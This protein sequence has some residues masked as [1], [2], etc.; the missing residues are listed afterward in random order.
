MAE[1]GNLLTIDDKPVFRADQIPEVPKAPYLL[2]KGG[3]LTYDI[4]PSCKFGDGKA[5]IVNPR[6]AKEGEILRDVDLKYRL[7]TSANLA[8]RMQVRSITNE[9]EHARELQMSLCRSSILYFCNVWC[10]TFI[11]G[12]EAVPFILYDFQE[13]L[14]T[15]MVFLI[16]HQISGLVEKSRCQGLS[17]LSRVVHAWMI[18]FFKNKIEYSLSLGKTEVDDRTMDSLFGKERFLLNH[19][20]DWMRGGWGERLEGVDNIMRVHIPKTGGLLKGLLTGSTAGRSGRGSFADYDEFAHVES[21]R[22]TLE[23]SSSLATC[24]IYIS[25]VKG[26]NNPFAAMA[27]A[28]G[29]IKKS[30]HWRQNPVLNDEWAIKERSKPK[31]FTD[32]IWDQEMEI[33]YESSTPGRVFP[34]LISSLEPGQSDTENW[35]HLQSG[36]FFEYDPNYPVQLGMDFGLSDPNTC[37]FA[38]IKPALPYFQNRLNQCVVI[39]D[40]YTKRNQGFADDEITGEPGLISVIKSKDYNYDN[41]IGDL[42]TADKRENIS[43]MRYKDFFK[44]NGLWLDGKRNRIEATIDTARGLLVLPGFIAINKHNCKGLVESLQNWSTPVDDSGNPIPGAKP[45]A[46]SQYSHY[47]KAFLY[48]LDFLYGMEKKKI[49]RVPFKWGLRV[50]ET[51][52]I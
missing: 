14:I 21:A 27:H 29:T 42:Y 8:Y 33:K 10:W 11:P 17:W 44:K 41:I 5:V 19:L 47:C 15:W 34:Q 46:R 7:D 16:K 24:E 6:K 26:M 1:I 23:A 4:D 43:K 13:D 37:V 18:L 45:E 36:D 20:P 22:E 3:E 31:Y 52:R 51:A 48:L 25:T 40:E 49:I 39:F 50:S 30:I 12:Q 35:S 32:E 28:P 2:A 38:Q 9:N